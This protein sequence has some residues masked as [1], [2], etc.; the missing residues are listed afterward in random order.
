MANNSSLLMLNSK[1][2]GKGLQDSL[3]NTNF[4]VKRNGYTMTYSGKI[5]KHFVKTSLAALL[6]SVTTL[7]AHAQCVNRQGL[8]MISKIL[9]DSTVTVK[10]SYNAE[11]ELTCVDYTYIHPR[12]IEHDRKVFTKSGGTITCK[13][14][15]FGKPFGRFEY[16]FTL[17]PDGKISSYIEYEH[18]GENS[19][20]RTQY[21]LS[22]GSGGKFESY[23]V[24]T[25]HKNLADPRTW[26][27]GW[28][29]VPFDDPVWLYNPSGKGFDFDC[30]D[31][32][33]QF[34]KKSVSYYKN[35]EISYF[36]DKRP[37]PVHYTD[38][39]NDINVGIEFMAYSMEYFLSIGMNY[40]VIFTEW[41]GLRSRCTVDFIHR[42]NST[43][44]RYQY[45][46][47]DNGNIT[48]LDV[49]KTVFKKDGKS[50]KLTRHLEIEYV[51]DD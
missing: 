16:E 31:G 22:Y 7:V 44:H 50:E 27:D 51:Y 28:E 8:K 4:A 12:K 40:F 26:Y 13:H 14:Y 33:Y 5:M 34:K 3:Y 46:Y 19:M 25:S 1:M 48:S 9:V 29:T 21:D 45:T 39:L 38:Y 42:A 37:N 20:G 49:Y 35:N 36:S 6:F 18:T 41:V 10:F 2:T 24:T 32:N 47:D 11:R 17:R 23:L 43:E 15:C 30:N